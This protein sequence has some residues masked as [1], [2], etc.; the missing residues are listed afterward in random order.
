MLAFNV[1][2]RVRKVKGYTLE[3][4]VRAVFT[5]KRGQVRYAVEVEALGGTSFFMIYSG[6]QLE[7]AAADAN[8]G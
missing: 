6:D 7:P 8:G 2:E 5:G 4:E 3:G 1:G